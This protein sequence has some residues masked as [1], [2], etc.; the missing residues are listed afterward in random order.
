[1]TAPASAVRRTI[2]STAYVAAWP[3][4]MFLLAGDV[5][6]VEGW[7]FAVWLVGLYL[8]VT[9]WM[10]FRDP[11]LLAERRRRHTSAAERP[12]RLLLSLMF[13]GFAAWM[14]L[15]PLDARRYHWSDPFP[16][17]AKEVGGALLALAAFLLF[18]AVHDNTF[19]GGVVRIQSERKHQV[20]STGVYAVVRHPMYLGMV[21]M[22]AGA[23]LL[24]G[25]VHALGMATAVTVEIGR[26]QV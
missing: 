1:M 22:L 20:V 2:A 24:L 16:L 17:S 8:T 19:L 26:A 13:T 14:I 5:R 18:R 6:W 15:M 7:I 11:A 21:L 25:S 9:L 23:P 10:H 12:D 3:A 4:L